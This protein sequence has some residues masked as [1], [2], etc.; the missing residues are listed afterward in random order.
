MD[1]K[2]TSNEQKVMGNK[3]KATSNKQKVRSNKQKVRSN[4]QK[5]TSYKQ[6]VTSNKQKATSNKQKVTSNEQK[7]SS[8]E[9]LQCRC[10]SLLTGDFLPEN[11]FYCSLYEKKHRILVWPI[12][13][14]KI[15]LDQQHILLQASAKGIY[16]SLS[17]IHTKILWTF[18]CMWPGPHLHPNSWHKFIDLQDS[19]KKYRTLP[20]SIISIII[21]ERSKRGRKYL[22]LG[23]TTYRPDLSLCQ[24]HLD[25][26]FVTS[27]FGLLHVNN[28]SQ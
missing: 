26:C 16:A 9:Q 25:V 17:Y 22:H 18:T 14:K 3:Q 27:K 5:A 8:N 11:F 19:K 20:L 15:S 10:T 28:F 6:N 13:F 2:V 4:K 12:N 7:A 23:C 24:M 21:K 1:E